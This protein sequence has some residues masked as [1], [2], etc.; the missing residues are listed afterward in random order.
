[1][2]LLLTYAFCMAL[3]CSV[4]GQDD[5]DQPSKGPYLPI[6]SITHLATYSGVMQVNNTPENLFNRALEWLDTAFRYSGA[7]LRLADLATGKIICKESV[8]DMISTYSY[9]TLTYTLSI[10]IENGGY[11]Y[12]FTNLYIDRITPGGL[13]NIPVEMMFH[14]TRKQ[15]NS[16]IGSGSLG[17]YQNTLNKYLEPI[18]ALMQIQAASF[19]HSMTKDTS[20]DKNAW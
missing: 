17:G 9:V 7:E 12:K 13:P 6:D 1:M 15:Y 2:K 11:K 3:C 16:I 20:G 18:D 5:A 10:K 4:F 14:A 19:N 8:L